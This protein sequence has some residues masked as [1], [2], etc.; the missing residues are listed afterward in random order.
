MLRQIVSSQRCGPPDGVVVELPAS[1]PGGRRY[2]P[3]ILSPDVV[4]VE[5]P[6]STPG[7]RRFDSGEVLKTAQSAGRRT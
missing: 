2:D 7:G 1:T 5:P 3:D 4:V 6:A